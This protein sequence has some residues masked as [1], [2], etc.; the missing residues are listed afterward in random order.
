[1]LQ[2][3][4]LDGMRGNSWLAKKLDYYMG[5]YNY[6]W[7][8][9][10]LYHRLLNYKIMKNLAEKLSSNL[11]KTNNRVLKLTTVFNLILDN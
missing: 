2:Q 9:G 6:K 1:M 8:E 3:L 10:S 11:E 5:H 7:T 4:K